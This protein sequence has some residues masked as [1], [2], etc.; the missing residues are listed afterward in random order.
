MPEERRARGLPSLEEIRKGRGRSRWPSPKFWLW[1]GVALAVATI[2]HW[3]RSQGQIE[4]ARQE[5]KAR[6]RAV[7]QELSP[8]WLPLR[9]AVEAWTAELARAPVVAEHVDL[10]A[11]RHWEFRDKAGLYLRLPV[12][13][14]TEVAAIRAGAKKSLRDGFTACLLR[15]PNDSPL[16]GKECARTR[17]CAV[18]ESCNELDRCARPSQPYNLRVAYRSLQ[19]LSDE[20]ARDVDTAAGELEVRMLTSSFEDTV[21]DDLPVAVDLLTRAQYFLLVLDEPPAGEPGGDGDAGASGDAQLTAPHMARLGLWRLSDRKLV[22]RM[23]A[24]ASATLIGGVTVTDA[25]VAAARQRQANSCALAGAFRRV[26]ERVE[27]KPAPDP[28]A[29]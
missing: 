28:T 14:A 13:Q 19:V 11:A 21:R 20:W 23:R 15:A 10:E 1:V 26:L 29:E 7:A 8:R 22:V 5:L 27:T 4:S 3:K 18:G 25:D 12:E 2:F 6:Q 9:Q 24:E 17:D 16:V